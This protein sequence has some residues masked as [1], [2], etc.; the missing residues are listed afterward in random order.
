M[1]EEIEHSGLHG[2]TFEIEESLPTDK[3]WEVLLHKIKHPDQFLPVSDVVTRVSDDGLG[4]YREMS[5]ALPTGGLTRIIENI[6]AHK[7]ALEVLFVVCGDVNE[8]V[9]AISVNA[10]GKRVLEFYLRNA[11]TKERVF[12]KV[13]KKIAL[14]GILK[15]LEMARSL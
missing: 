3:V 7:D 6:Y 11:A 15:V 5:I 1:A 14:G 8:H 13:P 10:D 4:T 2:A 9:N 12:W